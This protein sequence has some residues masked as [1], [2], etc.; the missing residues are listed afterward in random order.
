MI[1]THSTSLRP[2]IAP[3]SIPDTVYLRDRGNRRQ[4][5]TRS[6]GSLLT[7]L[8]RID[9]TY[10]PT[11]TETY[12]CGP[13]DSSSTVGEGRPAELRDE[14]VQNQLHS[15][16]CKRPT[17]SVACPKREPELRGPL[18]SPRPLLPSRP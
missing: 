8:A 13:D 9:T 4:G 17:T 12:L 10:I 11:K 3:L 1:A 18:H 14:Q 2:V 16:Q 6:T 7:K 15:R 5:T